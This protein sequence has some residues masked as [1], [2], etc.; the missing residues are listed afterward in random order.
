MS[1]KRTLEEKTS[2]LG[3]EQLAWVEPMQKWIEQAQNMENIAQSKNLFEKKVAAKEIFGSNLLLT[4]KNVAVLTP[5]NVVAENVVNVVSP[6]ENVV[7][8][9]KNVVENVVGGGEKR[10]WKAVQAFQNL[11]KEKPRGEAWQFVAPG[12]GF[13]PRYTA[14][15]AVVLPLDDPGTGAGILSYRV[16]MV[17]FRLNLI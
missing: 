9:G 13:E 17:N 14:S 15:K 2:R 1:Q 11:A 5:E 16:W 8:I 4:Q 7:V 10:H 6:S 12:L 3:R